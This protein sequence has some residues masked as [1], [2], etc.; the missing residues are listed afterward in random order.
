MA[1]F[2]VY[3]L[4]RLWKHLCCLWGPSS[5]SPT[6]PINFTNNSVFII[7][8]EK[9]IRVYHLKHLSEKREGPKL[10]GIIRWSGLEGT[11]KFSSLAMGGWEGYESVFQYVCFLTKYKGFS[12]GIWE[13]HMLKQLSTAYSVSIS[14]INQLSYVGLYFLFLLQTSFSPKTA[15]FTKHNLIYFAKWSSRFWCLDHLNIIWSCLFVILL[16]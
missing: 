16:S 5:N 1:L 14:S 6:E 4:V 12:K 10:H 11:L 9:W 3:L 8:L 7:S 13:K 2:S 15:W